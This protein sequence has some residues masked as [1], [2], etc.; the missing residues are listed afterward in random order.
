MEENRY[1]LETQNNEVETA[2][3]NNGL[4]EALILGVGVIVG[5]AGHWLYGK[6]KKKWQEHKEKKAALAER[7]EVIEGEVT[8]VEDDETEA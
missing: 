4:G 8:E 1:D 6:A 2:V 3:Q 7:P 5:A